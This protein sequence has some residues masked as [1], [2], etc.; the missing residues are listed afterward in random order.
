MDKNN[1]SVYF[2]IASKEDETKW[3]E[4]LR[5]Y[6]PNHY[7]KEILDDDLV[8]DIS[9]DHRLV[10]RIAVGIDGYGWLSAMCLHYGGPEL[11][12]H[13]NDFEEFKSTSIYKE[14]IKLGINYRV[15]EPQVITKK[16]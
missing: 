4:F 2:E 16:K 8:V 12:I 3:K 11:F 13:I 6:F 10:K 9:K 15:G 7:A 14:I 1:P 5:Y